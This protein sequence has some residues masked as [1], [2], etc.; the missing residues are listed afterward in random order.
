MNPV[1]IWSCVLKT[2]LTEAKKRGAIVQLEEVFHLPAD[3]ERVPAMLPQAVA[4]LYAYSNGMKVSWR[5]AHDENVG[6]QLKFTNLDHFLGSWA[7]A[8]YDPD[9]T[10]QDA[11]IR[12]FHVLDHITNEAQCGLVIHP[13]K[14][15]QEI[16]YNETGSDRL[17][18]LDLDFAGY[19]E[20]A[21]AASV[22]EYWPKVLVDIQTGNE[23]AETKKF[24]ENMPILFPDFSWSAFV[25]KYGSLRTRMQ[26]MRRH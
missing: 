18:G 19:L 6:G 10:G 25:E 21:T 23:S 8:I 11:L 5:A 9:R 20:M 26:D 22:Y 17:Y 7:G 15:D 2:A 12:D 1:F 14:F 13:G 3:P 24:K 16:W 4:D